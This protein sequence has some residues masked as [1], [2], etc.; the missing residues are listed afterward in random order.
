MFADS[1]KNTAMNPVHEHVLA[2]AQLFRSAAW[3]FSYPDV[4][5]AVLFTSKDSLDSHRALFDAVAKGRSF[6]VEECDA[7]EDAL[8]GYPPEKRA[9]D[10]RQ[11]YTRLFITPP[12]RISLI[13]ASWVKEKTLIA[14]KKGEAYAVGQYYRSLGLV[15]QKPVRDPS[16]HLVSELDFTSY[17]VFAEAEAW[18]ENDAESALEWRDL[19]EEFLSNHLAEFATKV[20]LEIQRE[21]TS[22]F[23]LF[24][25]R[26]LN[27][28]I[29]LSI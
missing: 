3:Q 25:A 4:E 18:R 15:N 6:M 24:S 10:L 17:V 16:D 8:V 14:R 11:E 22:P 26:M 28:L 2:A 21:T 9:I 19:K 1:L 27:G 13:G 5:R 23:L 12:I 7:L 20:S 29:G